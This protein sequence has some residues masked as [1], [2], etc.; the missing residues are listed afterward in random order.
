MTH[1]PVLLRISLAIA[2]LVTGGHLTAQDPQTPPAAAAK[3]EATRIAELID[4]LADN[5]FAR[6]EAA[7]KEL[8]AI[9][10]PAWAALVKV[11]AGTPDLEVRGRARR[12]LATIGKRAFVEVRRFTGHSDGVLTVAVSPDGRRALSGS[13]Q[14]ETDTFVRLWDVATANELRRLE[15]HTRGITAV[16]FSPDGKRALSGSLDKTVRLWDLASG[17]QVKSFTGHAQGVY[18]VAFSPDGKRAASAGHETPIRI[19][20][21]EKEREQEPLEG[22]TDAVRALAF[23]P[24]GRRLASSSV[25]GT[26]RLWDFR[27]GKIVR[28]LAVANPGI[29][30]FVAYSGDGRRLATGSY[31]GLVKLWDAET[32]KELQRWKGHETAIHAIAFTPDGRLLSGGLDRT[33]CVWDADTG[34]ELYR[35]DGHGD[36]VLGVACTPDGRQA[37]SASY[38]RTVRVWRLPPGL[39]GK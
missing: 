1:A 27:S 12:L 23:S 16:A 32:G 37:L 21:L 15:G 31:D 20:D 19:W 35:Y 8:A 5:K 33:L 22:H 2:A 10:E 18:A 30:V 29:W 3:K 6:R 7:S 38:D 25:D 14:G 4:Q 26:V 36:I 13:W 11:V 28:T 9:G 17:K 34:Q 24:D 39:G